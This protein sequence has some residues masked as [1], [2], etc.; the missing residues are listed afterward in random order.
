MLVKTQYPQS[1]K[2]NSQGLR[3]LPSGMQN[4]F[5][6]EDGLA[7]LGLIGIS[8]RDQVPP[9]RHRLNNSEERIRLKTSC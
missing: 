1:Y 2:C 4:K 9:F 8:L 7:D 3:I 6:E 5:L